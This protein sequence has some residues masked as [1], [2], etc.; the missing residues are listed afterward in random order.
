[1]SERDNASP[2]MVRMEEKAKK[3]PTVVNPKLARECWDAGYRNYLDLRKR[4]GYD[5][6]KHL[7]PPEFMR[8]RCDV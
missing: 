8:R 1:M 2:M 5:D 4:L 3:L 6:P 7:P